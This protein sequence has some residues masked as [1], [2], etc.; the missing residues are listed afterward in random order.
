MH[1]HTWI[2]P[3]RVTL[4]VQ[5]ACAKQASLRKN[6]AILA[7]DIAAVYTGLRTAVMVDYMPLSTSSMLAIL[8][9]V[10]AQEASRDSSECTSQVCLQ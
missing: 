6:A 8:A 4:L 9:D 5:K 2:V 3:D 7:R 1:A 10:Q